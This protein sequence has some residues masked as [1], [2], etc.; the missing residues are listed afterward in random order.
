[1]AALYKAVSVSTTPVLIAAANP[2]RKGI[3]LQSTTVAP[4]F[5][6][7]DENITTSNTVFV[8]AGGDGILAGLPEAYKGAIYGVVI[9]GTHSVKVFE[10]SE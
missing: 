9:A 2:R 10:W 6:G 1:M 4:L 8:R 7:N 3:I 5:W